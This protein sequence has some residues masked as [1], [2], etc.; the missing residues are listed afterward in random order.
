VSNGNDGIRPPADRAARGWEGQ[1]CRR[2]EFVTKIL[3]LKSVSLTE[4]NILRRS[5][6]ILLLVKEEE[7]VK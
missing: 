5:A 4:D 3:G 2:L 6:V 7:L 1:T